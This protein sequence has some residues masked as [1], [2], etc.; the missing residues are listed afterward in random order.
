MKKVALD[1]IAGIERYEQ[2]RPEFRRRIIDMKKH[3]RVAVGDQVTFV[4]ENHDSMLFQIQEMLRA[5]HIVDLDRVRA[6]LDVYNALIPEPGEL[7]ATMLIEITEAERIREQLVRL[8]GIDEAV[9]LE[10]GRCPPIRAQFEPGRSK[11]DKLSAVQ[12]VRFA[13]D[14]DARTAFIH[15]ADP[16]RLVIDH[17]NYRQTALLDGAVR[18]ALAQDLEAA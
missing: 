16:V 8:I 2:L 3:R 12:Y 15:R 4:F 9:R 7:S 14:D 1:E 6:E 18:R 13:L 11:E 5:E 10:V 17:P